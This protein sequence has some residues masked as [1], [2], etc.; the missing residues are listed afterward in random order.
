MN[1]LLSQVRELR[2]RAGLQQQELAA[3]AGISRQSLSALEAGTAVPS[4]TVA[5]AL[6]R[7]L[8]CRVE[9]LFALAGADAPRGAGARPRGAA[10]LARRARDRAGD[11][12]RGT[13]GGTRG[14]VAGRSWCPLA[15]PQLVRSV[16][17]GGQ[18]GAIL[19]A[20][21]VHDFGTSNLT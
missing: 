14:R 18:A 3:R 20:G 15:S 13:A 21:I 1:T 6:A 2:Q 9:D 19:V 10:R 16:A 7:T 17:R 8:G 5:L 11:G 12:I 4:T